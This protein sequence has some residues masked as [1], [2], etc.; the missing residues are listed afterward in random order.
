MTEASKKIQEYFED[1]EKGVDKAYQIANKARAKGYDPEDKVSIPR[2][3]NMAERVIGLV[4]AIATQ[5]LDPTVSGK[6][7][8]RIAELEKEYG[9]LDWRISLIIAEEIAR[10]KYCKFKDKKEAMEIGVR[11]GFAYHTMGTVSSPLEGFSELKIKK[12]KD[13]KEYFSVYFSWR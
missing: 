8:S 1:I 9:S 7:T 5:F 12:T 13:G 11:V 4:S 6:I 2:A 10:E 3:R